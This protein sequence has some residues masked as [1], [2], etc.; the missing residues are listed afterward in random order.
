MC[1]VSS[2]ITTTK[3][4]APEHRY[5][6]R[7]TT[8]LRRRPPIFTTAPIA[9]MKNLHEISVY[10]YVR[11]RGKLNPAKISTFPYTHMH[12]YTC[13]RMC[14]HIHTENG[15]R[16]WRAPNWSR[17]LYTKGNPGRSI[18]FRRD[19]GELIPHEYT[20][21]GRIPR[22]MLVSISDHEVGDSTSPNCQVIAR[23]GNEMDSLVN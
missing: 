4:P 20:R 15:R 22:F 11:S 10:M 2:C 3:P 19:S 14:M 5:Y 23:K 21:R 8:S 16:R 1:D 7:R 17:N 18:S 13:T 9:R 12:T 6:R